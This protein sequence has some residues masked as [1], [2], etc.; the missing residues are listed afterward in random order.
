MLRT[1]NKVILIGTITSN[2]SKESLR[3]TK[4]GV[5]VTNFTVMT[6]ESWLDKDKYKNSLVKQHNVVCWGKIAE[7]IVEQYKKGSA[8]I[9]DGSLAYKSQ[10][11]KDSKNSIAEIKVTNISPWEQDLSESSLNRVILIG[12]VGSVPELRQTNNQTYVTNFSL[13]TYNIWRDNE[14]KTQ[15]RKKWHKIVC[16][17]KVA[18][19]V[20]KKVKHKDVILLEGSLSYRPNKLAESPEDIIAEIKTS[21]VTVWNNIPE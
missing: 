19:E 5:P 9:I 16:W 18:E 6:T 13:N 12:D 14:R 21:Y 3:Q 1:M 4:S 2:L 20:V 15:V 11:N 8:V 7:N 17:G 10:K